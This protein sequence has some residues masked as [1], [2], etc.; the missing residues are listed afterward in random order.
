MAKPNKS[1]HF[2]PRSY[3][4]GWVDRDGPPNHTPAVWLFPKDGGVGR[5]KAPRNIFAETDMYTIPM[6]D[7]GRDLRIERGLSYLEKGI[8]DLIENFVA[9]RR[10]L[11]EHRFVRL[12]AFIAAMHGRTRRFRDHQR[13]QWGNILS[14]G[15]E[16]SRQ[17]Q[18]ASPEQRKRMTSMSLPST[19]PKMDL[20]DVRRL[21]EMPIQMMM[22]SLLS[23]EVPIL[24]QM[25]MTIYCTDDPTGFITSDDPVVWFDPE[26]PKR[27]PMFQGAALMYDSVEITMPLSPRH[28]VSIAH[29]PDMSLGIK[30]VEYAD[31]WPQ[32]V[33]AMNRRTVF[34]AEQ[35]V[36]VS[37]DEYNPAWNIAALP[38]GTA[39][40]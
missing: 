26:A 22:S 36:V 16:V 15:E 34:Y 20:D 33:L 17:Y 39:V 14:M 5:K 2:I 7:G 19:G 4:A 10:Q 37:R 8:P 30:P 24:S 29:A 12:I 31:A 9:R 18:D 27:P 23:A 6:P 3:L 13:E 25:Q 11:P 38:Q 40:S 32:T 28:L 35:S 21:V 1:Q